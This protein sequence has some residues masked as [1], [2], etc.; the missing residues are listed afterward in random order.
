MESADSGYSG[1]TSLPFQKINIRSDVRAE[2]ELKREK[3]S[4]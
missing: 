2:F 4:K 3:K 1:E